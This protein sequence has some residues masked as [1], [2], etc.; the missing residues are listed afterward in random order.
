MSFLHSW[1][2]GP[3]GEWYLEA[4]NGKAWWGGLS[5]SCYEAISEIGADNI[6]FMDFGVDRLFLIRY[7]D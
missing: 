2:P 4:R 6:T 3:R 5:D 7:C 1:Q